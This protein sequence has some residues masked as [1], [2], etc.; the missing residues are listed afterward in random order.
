MERLKKEGSTRIRRLTFLVLHS[1]FTIEKNLEKLG[2]L[3]EVRKKN[4]FSFPER[5]QRVA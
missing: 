3:G 4:H 1:N 2:K 5:S